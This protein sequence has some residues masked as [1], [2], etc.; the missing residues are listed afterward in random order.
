MIL[1]TGVV[2]PQ[3]SGLGGGFFLNFYNR[4]AKK[5]YIIDA[6]ETAP[7]NSDVNMFRDN[8]ILSEEG[9]LSIAI[10]GELAGLEEAHRRFGKLPWKR[11]F[12]GAINLAQNGF[13][14]TKHLDHALQN[15]Q[16]FDS[17][18]RFPDLRFRIKFEKKLSLILNNLFIREYLTNK[19]TGDFYREGEVMKRPEYAKTLQI[20]ANKGSKEFYSGELTKTLL[21]DIRR[22]GE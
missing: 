7:N 18:K 20:I 16:T 22:N 19:K 17:I 12:E 4:T 1:C 9:G 11:L 3:S 6:R 10:P 2:L 21:A 5:A 13:S 15:K 8:S 14:I